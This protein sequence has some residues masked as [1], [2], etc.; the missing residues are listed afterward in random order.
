MLL[1]WIGVDTG[2]VFFHAILHK[3]LLHCICS[4]ILSTLWEQKAMII[5]F[6]DG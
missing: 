3:Q 6:E 2:F 4:F 5:P 1:D